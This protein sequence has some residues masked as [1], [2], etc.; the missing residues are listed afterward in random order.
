MS[1]EQIFTMNLMIYVSDKKVI[2]TYFHSENTLLMISEITFQEVEDGL[3]KSNWLLNE[4]RQ[5]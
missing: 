2:F 5:R 3:I 1:K 4:F